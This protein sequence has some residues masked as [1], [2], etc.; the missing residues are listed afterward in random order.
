MK[1]RAEIDGLRTLAVLP[2]VLFHAGFST[3]SG[4]FVG[5]DI[6]FVIS[7]FLITGIIAD[8]ISAGQFSLLHFYERRARRILPALFSVIF[9]CW[10]CALLWMRPD[11]IESFATSAVA[12]IFF[13]ANIYFWRDGTAYFAAA[14]EEQALLHTWSLSV[15]EQFYILF[16]LFFLL[17]WKRGGRTA[18]IGTSSVAAMSLLLN[19]WALSQPWI[20]P[21]AVFY[22]LPTRAWELL[23]G[24]ICAINVRRLGE[25]R[26]QLGA[27]LGLVAILASIFFYDHNIPSPS[28]YLIVPVAGTAAILLFASGTVVGAILSWRPMVRIGLISYSVYLWHQPLFAFA[29]IRL[30]NEPSTAILLG[31]SAL[32]LLLGWMSWRF[33]ELPFRRAGVRSI[34]AFRLLAPIAISVACFSGLFAL[35]IAHDGFPSRFPHFQTW[36]AGVSAHKSKPELD[37]SFNRKF[38]AAAVDD[39]LDKSEKKILLI[40][41]SHA[42]ALSAALLMRLQK[43]GMAAAVVTNHA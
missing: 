11:Q 26:N 4:G 43:T 9:F 20:S 16:P 8:E 27:F 35:T 21:S 24:A 3:F 18:L 2:V 31:L 17:L 13:T 40:G 29:R 15:E 1:Y 30:I 10:L 34:S 12:A 6:F 23:S 41:D 42:D 7:G 28:A 25:M 38:R 33:V 5:V 32:S 14:S 37:C 39:C 36:M 19:L 22:L